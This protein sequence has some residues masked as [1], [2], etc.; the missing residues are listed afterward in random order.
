MAYLGVLFLVVA[1]AVS[2]GVVTQNED[3]ALKREKEQDWLFIGKQYQ[4]AITSYYQ[5][6]PSGLKA[7]PSK[8]EDLLRDKRFIAPV[9][10]LRKAYTDPMNNQANWVLMLNQENQII[11]VYSASQAPILSNKIV[12][13]YAAGAGEAFTSYADVKFLYETKDTREKKSD[14][15]QSE[16]AFAE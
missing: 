9:R 1:I 12:N 13:D 16:D 15:M 2:L 14:E 4:Q 11:G 6:S 7:F 3:T 10:H 8:I 5:Q